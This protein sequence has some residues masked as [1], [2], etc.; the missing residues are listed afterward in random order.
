MD[1]ARATEELEQAL[2]GGN[3]ALAKKLLEMM[4][5]QSEMY[6]F[7][8][9]DGGYTEALRFAIIN[10]G[11]VNSRN[12]LGETLLFD[13]IANEDYDTVALLISYKANV[14]AYDDYQLYPI[15]EA[16]GNQ[17]TDILQLLIDSGANINAV[18]RKGRSVLF[19]FCR[20]LNVDGVDMLLK[21][22]ADPNIGPSC[23]SAAMSS[24]PGSLKIIQNLVDRR[25]NITVDDVFNAMNGYY[26]DI[27]HLLLDYAPTP[28]YEYIINRTEFH[29]YF[30]QLYKDV[31]RSR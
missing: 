26:H 7:T 13:T 29:D 5:N 17:Y 10:G 23:I 6:M 31:I 27:L 25:A 4:K 15:M 14:N 18:D 12:E 28:V 2:N 24:N 20:S 19:F 21:Y 8:L 3:I 16:S 1:I 11:N 9:L 30:K 22:G